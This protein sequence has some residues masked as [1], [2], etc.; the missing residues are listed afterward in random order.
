MSKNKVLFTRIR[1]FTSWL[2]CVLILGT[3]GYCLIEG[4]TAGEGFYMTVITMATVGYGE[5]HELSQFGR[6]FTCVLIFFSIVSLSCWTACLTSLFVDR[7]II[8]ALKQKKA[9]KMAKLM[10]NHAVVCGTGIMAQTVIAKLV[11][12]KEKV[13]VIDQDLEALQEISRRY[14]G[15]VT[16]EAPAVDEFALADANVLDAKCILAVLDSD[17]DNL[18]IS[19]TCKDLGTDVKVIARSDDFQVASRM[20]KIGVDNV[21]CPFQLSG[22]EAAKLACMSE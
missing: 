12:S 9:K 21:I 3:I 4:W 20:S 2:A 1:G 15:V 19:M 14:P 22:E 18:M 6:L 16:I 10:K 17:F 5:T 8:G 13:V 7:E 11:R